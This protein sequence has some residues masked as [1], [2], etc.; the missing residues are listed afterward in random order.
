MRLNPGMGGGGSEQED[1]KP[2][3]SSA[4]KHRP[5]VQ[6]ECAFKL[7]DSPFTNGLEE[8]LKRTSHG[9]KP[10]QRSREG[11]RTD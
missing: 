9:I 11:G 3:V 1:E 7:S 2:M 6:E 5:G 10:K 8:K 4:Q